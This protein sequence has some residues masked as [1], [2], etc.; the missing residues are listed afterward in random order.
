MSSIESSKQRQLAGRR[1]TTNPCSVA[2]MHCQSLH[3]NSSHAHFSRSHWL[4]VH[5]RRHVYSDYRLHCKLATE[6]ERIGDL[7]LNYKLLYEDALWVLSNV[8]PSLCSI[9]APNSKAKRR[10][11]T[12]GN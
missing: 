5:G 12:R 6:L 2:T 8:H 4:Q 9:L 7:V 10:R 11:K 1:Q 3:V